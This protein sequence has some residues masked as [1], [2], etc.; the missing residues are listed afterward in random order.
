MNY[1]LYILKSEK[2]ETYYTGCSDDPE[3]RCYF[4]NN[5]SKGYTLAWRPWELV[6]SYGFETKDQALAAERK[7]KSWKSKKMIRLLVEGKIDIENYL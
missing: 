4:H 1:F 6:Y 5:D 7:V 3:R 2:K